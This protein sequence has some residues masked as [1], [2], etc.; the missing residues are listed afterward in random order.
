L[1]G[2]SYKQLDSTRTGI[3]VEEEEDLEEDSEE[4]GDTDQCRFCDK[5]VE[6][7]YGPVP[8]PPTPN[9]ATSTVRVCLRLPDGRSIVR[10]YRADDSVM[11]LYAV[12]R[13]ALLES[14]R[15]FKPKFELFSTCPRIGLERYLP[16][17][18][19][20]PG[21]TIGEASLGNSVVVV[22]FL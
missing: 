18:T 19:S 5:T 3:S 4:N 22:E 10:R 20:C 15:E 13:E 9:C 14:E 2:R 7:S 17:L 1:I 16:S 12:T 6:S 8:P 21:T 11:A